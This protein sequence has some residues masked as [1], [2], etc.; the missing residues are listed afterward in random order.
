MTADKDQAMFT[1]IFAHHFYIK[2]SEMKVVVA[3]DSL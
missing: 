3:H 1:T 2:M